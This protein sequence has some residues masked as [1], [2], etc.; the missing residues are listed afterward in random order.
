MLLLTGYDETLI[1]GRRRPIQSHQEAT[2]LIKYKM[3]SSKI[4]LTLVILQFLIQ[5]VPRNPH[6]TL[7]L[8]SALFLST[9]IPISRLGCQYCLQLVS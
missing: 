5:I 9:A 6:Q 2:A 3:E 1:S 7:Q 8:S 4:D